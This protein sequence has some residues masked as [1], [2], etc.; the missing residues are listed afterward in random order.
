MSSVFRLYFLF[1]LFS[2]GVCKYRS[3]WQREVEVDSGEKE[4][5]G[6]FRVVMLCLFVAQGKIKV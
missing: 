4:K 6:I 2:L 5:D 1:E 3:E